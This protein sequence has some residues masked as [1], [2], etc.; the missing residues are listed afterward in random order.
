[1]RKL[2]YTLITFIL[3]LPSLL[4]A[5]EMP[6]W[7]EGW[8]DIHHIA[9]GKGE[10]SLFVFPDGTTMLVDLGDETNGRFKC[11]AYPDASRTPGQWVVRYIN[12]FAAGTPGKGEKVDY[13]EL[14]HFHS[15]HM[16]SPK[17]LREGPRYGLCGITDAGESLRFGKIV[18]RAYPDYARNIMPLT[19]IWSD[20]I[21]DLHKASGLY[22]DQTQFVITIFGDGN[23]ES[24]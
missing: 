1:M 5:Q 11:P 15:D 17:A 14:T 19:E 21:A 24:I 6:S 12:H 16:G 22:D 8:M 3:L 10:N 18:D 9:T 13:F 7:Q 2:S 23:E 20:R 4:R